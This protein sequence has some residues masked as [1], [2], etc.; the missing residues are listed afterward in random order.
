MSDN[1]DLLAMTTTSDEPKPSAIK[2]TT[3]SM[4]FT[5]T[6]SYIM[7]LSQ[8]TKQELFTA[9]GD[10]DLTRNTEKIEILNLVCPFSI[11]LCELAHRSSLARLPSKIP[12]NWKTNSA[13]M[14]TTR[15]PTF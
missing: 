11:P 5:R 8:Q 9:A 10:E 1:D 12:S 3:K 6:S 7:G 14:K 15:E 13:R 4:I 2:T